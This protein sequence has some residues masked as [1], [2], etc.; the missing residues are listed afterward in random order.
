MLDQIRAATTDLERGGAIAGG[1]TMGRRDHIQVMEDQAVVDSRG[2]GLIGESGAVQ[3]GD[4]EF[5]RSISRKHPARSIGAVRSRSQPDQQD[6]R[7]R[8][9]ISGDGTAPILFFEIGPAFDPSD[10][11][12]VGHQPR[13]TSAPDD[14]VIQQAKPGLRS[15][16]GA[17]HITLGGWTRSEPRPVV[18]PLRP[19]P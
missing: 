9:S 4:Q 19:S 12:A 13:A 15:E 8:I 18:G 6:P 1:R 3:S 16:L 7:L 14:C 10:S 2:G 11:F 17:C 5:R